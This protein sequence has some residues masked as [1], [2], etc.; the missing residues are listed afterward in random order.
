[1]Y[2]FRLHVSPLSLTFYP[3]SHLD[4]PLGTGCGR[5]SCLIVCVEPGERLLSV[6]LAPWGPDR[7]NRTTE[8]PFTVIA[9]P[10]SVNQDQ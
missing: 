4:H 2:T 3:C 8:S 10:V 1:M 6:Q 7:G 9:M 5:H